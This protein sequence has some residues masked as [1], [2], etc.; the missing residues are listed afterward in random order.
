MSDDFSLHPKLRDDCHLLGQ[1]SGTRVLLH[2]NATLHWFLLVPSTDVLDFTDLP[3]VEQQALMWLAT[4]I[5]DRLKG[6][7][8]YGRVNIGA[9]GLV[10]P[11]LHLHVIGRHEQDPCWPNPVWGQLPEGPIYTVG[12]LSSLS[13]WVATLGHESLLASP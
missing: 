8:G 4:G 11:Q 12:E 9:L 10:V 3:S 7:F 5:G 1:V 2:R 13:D 6:D